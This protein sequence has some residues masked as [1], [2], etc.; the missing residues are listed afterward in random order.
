MSL[1]GVNRHLHDDSDA[2]I[3]YGVVP[4]AVPNDPRV[5]GAYL[6]LQ[7][8]GEPEGPDNPHLVMAVGN[9]EAWVVDDGED[10]AIGDYLIAADVHGHA[11]KDQGKYEISYVVARAAEPVQWDGVGETVA[12]RKHRR[13]SVFFESFARGHSLEKIEALQTENRELRKS[14]E[15]LEAQMAR[16]AEKVAGLS[17]TED[18]LQQ[19][20]T[21]LEEL[22]GQMTDLATAMRQLQA[23][24]SR[25]GEVGRAGGE[26]EILAEAR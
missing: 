8:A 3:V 14:N 20:R 19:T 15:R 22:Q 13:I 1:T 25:T 18:E 17:G 4:S 26:S 2:E 21:R 12:G 10:I 11:M 16:L 7:D 6:S 9:G 24:K 5:M 23:D